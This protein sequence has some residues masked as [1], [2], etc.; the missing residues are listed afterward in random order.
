[1][2]IYNVTTKVDPSIQQAWLQWIKEEH[3][4]DIINTGCFIKGTVLHLL[5]IDDNEGPTYAVQYTA[6]SKALYNRY[7]DKFAPLMRQKAIDKWGNKF[8]AFRSL[9]QVIH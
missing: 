9:M 6:E 8:I 7:I 3:I 2:F 4:P 1:M 5:D